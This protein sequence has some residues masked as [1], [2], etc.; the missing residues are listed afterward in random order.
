[1]KPLAVGAWCGSYTNA[2]IFEL[3]V[4]GAFSISQVSLVQ[5]AAPRDLI[6]GVETNA[7]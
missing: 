5:F 7:I 1:M 3:T 2:I 4:T 6:E